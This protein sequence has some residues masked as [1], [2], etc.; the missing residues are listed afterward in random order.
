MHILCVL[1]FLSL[2]SLGGDGMMRKVYMALAIVILLS[3]VC[4]FGY[5]SYLTSKLND[6]LTQQTKGVMVI[7]MME[8]QDHLMAGIDSIDSTNLDEF[9]WSELKVSIEKVLNSTSILRENYTKANE[10]TAVLNSIWWTFDSLERMV[11]QSMLF[12]RDHKPF[13]LSSCDNIEIKSEDDILKEF[14][15]FR[16]II[17]VSDSKDPI[18]IEEYWKQ[19]KSGWDIEKASTIYLCEK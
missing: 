3:A 4:W 8:T 12:H 1:L 7:G 9:Y 6:K 11:T 17:E 5:K 19:I 18:E 15:T 14:Q 10:E 13:S 2:N 16:D